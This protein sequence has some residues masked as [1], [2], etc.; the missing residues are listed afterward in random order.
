MKLD[1][2]GGVRW[3]GVES[4]VVICDQGRNKK[5]R[6]LKG[7]DD[8]KKK[9]GGWRVSTSSLFLSSFYLPRSAQ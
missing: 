5:D 8:K 9:H 6:S 4:K 3:G 7:I 2:Y 1:H